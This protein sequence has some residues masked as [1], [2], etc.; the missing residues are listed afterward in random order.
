[1]IVRKFDLDD[2]VQTTR[3]PASFLT[4]L[5]TWIQQHESDDVVA[6]PFSYVELC[7][8]LLKI[9]P[10]HFPQRSPISGQWEINPGNLFER[11]TLAFYLKNCTEL[12]SVLRPPLRSIPC[13]NQLE[14]VSPGDHFSGRGTALAH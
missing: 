8:A 4:S 11:P 3:Y 1:M 9:D 12:L 5:I 10:V 7:I 14:Q 6:K 2:F 13:T